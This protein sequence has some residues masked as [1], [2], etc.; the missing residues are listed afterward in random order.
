MFT[1]PGIHVRGSYATNLH[2]MELLKTLL[3]HGP[4]DTLTITV[5]VDLPQHRIDEIMALAM[6]CGRTFLGPLPSSTPEPRRVYMLSS[7]PKSVRE[8]RKAVAFSSGKGKA[9]TGFPIVEAATLYK[10]GPGGDF[11]TPSA[12]GDRL[13]YVRF[14]DNTAT[15][16]NTGLAMRAKTALIIN[17][18]ANGAVIFVP[19]TAL[20]YVARLRTYWYTKNRDLGQLT[21]LR[22]LGGDAGM[23]V[24]ARWHVGTSSPRKD[25]GL[26]LSTLSAFDECL[27]VD[28]QGSL[29]GP[30]VVGHGMR[31]GAAN[32]ESYDPLSDAKDV[33]PVTP[34][35]G[36]PGIVSVHTPKS[37]AEKDAEEILLETTLKLA[38]DKL[39]YAYGVDSSWREW[40]DCVEGNCANVNDPEG[41]VALRNRA[42]RHVFEENSWAIPS[43]QTSTSALSMY[44][45]DLTLQVTEGMAEVKGP[46]QYGTPGERLLTLTGAVLP[47]AELIKRI[48]DSYK[49]NLVVEC[50]RLG[51]T[52]ARA[53]VGTIMPELG[54]EPEPPK[55]PEPPAIQLVATTVHT[56][57][58]PPRPPT[59]P[60]PLEVT[61]PKKTPPKPT[62]GEAEPSLVGFD[63]GEDLS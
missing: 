59:P 15:L 63:F 61:K 48:T 18:L 30:D 26:F 56:P 54:T 60:E 2:S 9:R 58:E 44:L 33:T 25:A 35:A 29:F 3:V 21:A 36:S 12:V 31:E 20:A 42:A 6:E 17:G 45:D 43:T 41:E 40:V 53:D 49:A 47:A 55:P 27:D 28:G 1:L 5:P 16:N 7:D 4:K 34:E 13:R 32:G 23:V 50:E 62:G 22:L 39:E 24:F 51:R 10:C 38:K 11:V 52:E 19:E 8:F 37:E 46:T 57:D 14:T